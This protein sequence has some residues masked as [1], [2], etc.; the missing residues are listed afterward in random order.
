MGIRGHAAIV[1]YASVSG[2]RKLHRHLKV[3]GMN[4]L[5]DAESEMTGD[6]EELQ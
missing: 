6:S 5:Q 2:Y 3:K 1:R 4:I